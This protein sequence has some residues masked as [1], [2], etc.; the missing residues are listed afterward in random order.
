MTEANCRGKVV[1]NN[2]YSYNMIWFIDDLQ[3][4]QKNPKSDQ[5]RSAYE[6]AVAPAASRK[7]DVARHDKKRRPR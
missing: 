7:D 4:P 1:R 6:Y 2:C 3:L 5:Q